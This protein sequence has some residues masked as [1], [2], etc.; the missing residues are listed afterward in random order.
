MRTNDKEYI[1][2]QSILHWINTN[3]LNK[4]NKYNVYVVTKSVKTHNTNRK[5][6][7]V[8]VI[9]WS[10]KLYFWL[11]SIDNSQNVYIS[12]GHLINNIL[13]GIDNRF[14]DNHNNH[15]IK[16]PTWR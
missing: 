9:R 4:I 11:S 15:L 14:T 3:V 8:K 1:K 6:N 7:I 12:Q 5:Y 16:K 2:Y 10:L 13:L